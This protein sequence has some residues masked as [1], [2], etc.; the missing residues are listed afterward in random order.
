[1]TE[2]IFML[3]LSPDDD[4]LEFITEFLDRPHIA[5]YLDNHGQDKI[6]STINIKANS[7]SNRIYVIKYKSSIPNLSISKLENLR[8]IHS[9][10][11]LEMRKE[12]DHYDYTAGEIAP[13]ISNTFNF[14]TIGAF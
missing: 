7:L 4:L 13:S 12:N 1:M 3:D 9:N 6:L 5:K 2:D 14:D 10:P 11:S 8:N